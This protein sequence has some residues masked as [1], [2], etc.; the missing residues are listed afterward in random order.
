MDNP[1]PAV[2]L[3]ALARA[4]EAECRRLGITP[5]EYLALV[6]QLRQEAREP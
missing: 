5:Q 1:T 4:I 3:A 2:D 6:E